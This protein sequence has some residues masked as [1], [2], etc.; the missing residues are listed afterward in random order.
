MISI[1]L[2]LRRALILLA[3]I[4]FAS[5][6]STKTAAQKPPSVVLG[7]AI[8]W[9]KDVDK[10]A[11]FYES[12]FGLSVKRKQDMGKFK[13]LEMKTGATTL[14]FAGETEIQGMFPDGYAGHDA[15]KRPIAAQISFVTKDVQASFAKAV[16]A[17]ALAIRT[18]SKMPW[19][20]TWAQ[21]RDPNGVLI[22]IASPL[23]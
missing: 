9:V 18:P 7:Y 1:D 6:L 22:S 4:A 21:L 12:A 13:W 5:S 8:L 10:A 19:G 16:A 2:V 11:E 14:A 23:P 17:G 20:Q 15:A 3:A